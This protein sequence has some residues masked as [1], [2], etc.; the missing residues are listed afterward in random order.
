[1]QAAQ[2][3]WLHQAWCPWYCLAW[4]VGLRANQHRPRFLTAVQAGVQALARR[5]AV[6]RTW[7]RPC[8]RHW[9]WHGRHS[10]KCC[11]QRYLVCL[12]PAQLLHRR[13]SA[14]IIQLPADT[15][16]RPGGGC[17]CGCLP[18]RPALLPRLACCRWCCLGWVCSF[19][20]CTTTCN[21]LRCIMC[22]GQPAELLKAEALQASQCII[23]I[24]GWHQVSRQHAAVQER[25]QQARQV[26]S[27]RAQLLRVA[28]RERKAGCC[29]A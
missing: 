19:G 13:H 23:S 25:Q 1:M 15:R 22:S 11:H 2:A 8:W 24:R 17:C 29:T 14:V 4:L 16:Q 7:C 26:G 3:G 27:C 18:T 6:S 20:R 21:R 10:L 5:R 28:V 9:L 12:H